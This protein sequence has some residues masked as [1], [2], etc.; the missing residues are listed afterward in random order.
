MIEHYNNFQISFYYTYMD[1]II[2]AAPSEFLNSITNYFNIVHKQLKF[3]MEV[4]NNINFLDVTI[5]I[6]ND[7]IIFYNYNKS[8]CSDRFLNF[9]S[10]HSP[11]YKNGVLINLVNILIL[12]S[13]ISSNKSYKG[14]THLT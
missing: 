12:S 7:T 10:Y 1:D 5:I 11:C 2:L 3:T 9:H 8:T 14:N 13:I 6:H 4:S